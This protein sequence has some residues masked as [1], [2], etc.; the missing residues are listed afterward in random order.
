MVCD[1]LDLRCIFVSEIAGTALMATMIAV[2]L[3]F[4]A[5]SRLNWGFNTTIGFLFPMLF[6][7]TLGIAGFSAV[8]AFSTIIIGALAAFMFNK[9]VGN[10]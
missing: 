3:Y 9:I 8:M 7:I 1:I 2:A 4:I 5:A 10:R 6:I